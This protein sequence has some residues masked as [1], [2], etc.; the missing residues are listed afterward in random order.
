MIILSWLLLTDIDAKLPTFKDK[1]FV[2][3]SQ[4]LWDPTNFYGHYKAPSIHTYE[5]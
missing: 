3:A 1:I 5:K 4:I 2:K